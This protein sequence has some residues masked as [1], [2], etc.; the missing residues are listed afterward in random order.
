M[1]NGVFTGGAW[2][3]IGLETQG[4]G[5]GSIYKTERTI[6]DYYSALEMALRLCLGVY[7]GDEYL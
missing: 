3:R 2:T 1:R 7:S 4:F 5:T 6:Y